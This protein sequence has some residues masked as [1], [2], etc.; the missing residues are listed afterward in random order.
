MY[1]PDYPLGSIISFQIEQ[2]FKTRNLGTEMERM[3]KQGSI[4]PG[5]WMQKAVGND[6]S[7]EPMLEVSRRALDA[8][9][10]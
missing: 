1:L 4:T 3:C 7:T 10:A 8:L 5:L 6:I 2:Y 9:G